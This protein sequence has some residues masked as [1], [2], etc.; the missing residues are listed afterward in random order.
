MTLSPRPWS[1]TV[2]VTRAPST[3]GRHLRAV[4]GGPLPLVFAPLEELL[5]EARRVFAG[6]EV[7]VFHD[8]LVQRDR[9]LYP[10]DDQHFERAA[11]AR[12]RHLARARVDDELGDQG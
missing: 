9:R 10:F 1:T 6:A 4:G 3:A 5:H 11:H 2:P 12:N 8:R 7:R